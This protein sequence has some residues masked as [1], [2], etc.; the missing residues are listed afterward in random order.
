MN[1]LYLKEPRMTRAGINTVVTLSAALAC[2]FVFSNSMAAETPT[3]TQPATGLS[4]ALP[5]GTVA[6]VNGEQIKQTE[7]DAAVAAT[8]QPDTPALRTNIENQLI[9]RAL[10][11]QAAQAAH[12][13]NHADVQAA[14]AQ[15][16]DMAM[17][18]AYLRDAVKPAAVSDADVKAQ[19]DKI[20]ASLGESEYK[21]S[22]IVTNDADTAQKVIDLL[23]KGGDFAQLAKQYSVAPDAAQGGALNWVSFKTPLEEG[24]TQNWPLPVADALLK[25]PVGAVSSAP[26]A[27]GG[28]FYV[29]HLEQKRPTQ[30]PDFATVKPALEKQMQLAAIQK[31][32]A[33]VVV[34]LLKNAKIQQS[35]H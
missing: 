35:Q 20:V 13:D 24:K 28:K 10:L 4:A 12:Y 6:V 29:L 21:A 9:A 27:V 34:G 8:H 32:T 33:E 2:A 31:A 19:F 26:L 11:A 18:Q 1:F 3:P 14:V 15:A 5:I 22:A 23:K 17:T 25:L 30:V 16:K 7:L